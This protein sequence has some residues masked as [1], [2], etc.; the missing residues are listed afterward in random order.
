M[1]I[2]PLFLKII[3]V[4]YVRYGQY[5][6]ASQQNCAKESPK[7]SA[8]LKTKSSQH[9]AAV[10]TH[11]AL[12]LFLPEL[13]SHDRMLFDETK[14]PIMEKPI[15]IELLNKNGML[16]ESKGF[17]PKKMKPDDASFDLYSTESYM[18]YPGERK[19]FLTKF[20]CAIPK[21]QLGL[22]HPRSSLWIQRLDVLKGLIHPNFRG[23]VKI[24]LENNSKQKQFIR[25]GDRIA[26]VTFHEANDNVQEVDFIDPWETDRGTRGFGSSGRNDPQT[27]Y[28]LRLRDSPITKRSERKLQ[29]EP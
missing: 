15:K 28:S 21:K 12:S 26:Q 24:G 20:R 19:F 11:L 10:Q 16:G 29:I 2:D 6:A 3:N 7:I 1:K 14:P 17:M 23:E 5:Q 8:Q 25:V 22:I 27:E 18:L 4:L 9:H 13:L